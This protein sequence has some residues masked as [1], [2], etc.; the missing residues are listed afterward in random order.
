MNIAN[1]VYCLILIFGFITA[2]SLFWYE[3]K[4]KAP[5]IP[6]LPWVRK[7]MIDGLKR[8]TDPT[9]S[10]K[11]A[12]LG[13]GWGGLTIKIARNFKSSQIDGYELAYAPYLVSKIRAAFAFRKIKFYRADFF[14]RDLSQYDIIVCYLLPWHMAQLKPQLEQL[15]PGSIIVVNA[16]GVPGWEPIETQYTEFVV[17]IPIYVYRR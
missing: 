13:S 2:F 10:Y 3:K 11:I 9:K 15:K 8:H 12:E 17:K 5:A 4:T 7:K 6:T 14:K 16:Y 1:I